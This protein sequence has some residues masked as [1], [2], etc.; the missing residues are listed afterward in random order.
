MRKDEIERKLKMLGHWETRKQYLL[1]QIAELEAAKVKLKG[2]EDMAQHLSRIESEQDKLAY[3]IEGKTIEISSVT[4]ALEVLP[5]PMSRLLRMRY[6]EGK[7]WFRV[8]MEIDYSETYV[9]KE[10][11][12]KALQMLADL[13]EDDDGE[14]M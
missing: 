6:V 14:A 10:L 13:M 2:R 5:E 4:A 12:D 9:R 7:E 3:E 8:A 11:R 1:C